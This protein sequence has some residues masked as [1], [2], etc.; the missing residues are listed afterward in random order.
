[1][2]NLFGYQRL[3]GEIKLMNEIYELASDLKNFYV[4]CLKLKKKE[5]IGSKI[6]KKYDPSKTP[7]QRLLDS[8]QL[9][10][11]QQDNL[12]KRKLGLNPFRIKGHLD[13][14]LAEFFS[15]FEASRLEIKMVA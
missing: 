8:G 12:I 14:K 10:I 2:R 6:K 15:K 4:P 3:S 5:R 13:K 11:K 7:Y 9:T 1:M